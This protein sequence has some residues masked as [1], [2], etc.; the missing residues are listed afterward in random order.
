MG[1][2]GSGRLGGPGRR[3]QPESERKKTQRSQA[4]PGAGVHAWTLSSSLPS[5]TLDP[6]TPHTQ[7]LNGTADEVAAQV[8]E[9]SLYASPFPFDT[10]LD[11][12]MGEWR[13]GGGGGCCR[14]WC[15]GRMGG[16][17][18]AHCVHEANVL[19][20][21]HSA[22]HPVLLKI[23]IYCTSPHTHALPPTRPAAFFAPHAP[24]NSIRM[25]RHLHSKDF[26]GSVFV[27]FKSKE[28][29]DKVGGNFCVCVTQRVGGWQVAG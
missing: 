4:T 20:R 9:R 17:E 21:L 11:Q 7:L 5:P 16:C 8:E 23:Q 25:R 28:E 13:W 10:T 1:E 14:A 3:M 12:L 26:K 27:E 19:A 18:W 22:Q 2:G 6:P 15:A 29:A 24:V